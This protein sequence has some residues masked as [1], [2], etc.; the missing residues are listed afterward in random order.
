MSFLD[1]KEK[2]LPLDEWVQAFVDW[3][4]LNYRDFFLGYS[5]YGVDHFSN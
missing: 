3:L 4:V 2:I 5:L 1:F